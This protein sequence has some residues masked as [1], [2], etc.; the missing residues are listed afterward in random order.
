MASTRLQVA[1]SELARCGPVKAYAQLGDNGVPR[2]PRLGPAFGT[3]FLYFCSPVGGRP[4]LI[5][6]R[7]VAAWLRANTDLWLNEARWSVQT[8]ERYLTAMFLWADEMAIAADE[9]EACIFSK[10]AEVTGSQ[11]ALS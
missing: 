10:Q 8:Y 4:A 5:L 2:L 3:K 11:W 1:A 9:L 6:D 7:L